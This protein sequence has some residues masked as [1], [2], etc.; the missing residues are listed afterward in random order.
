MSD[1]ESET[2]QNAIPPFHY[3]HCTC[4]MRFSSFSECVY[5]CHPSIY[6]YPWLIVYSAW[7]ICL[8]LTWILFPLWQVSWLLHPLPFWPFKSSMWLMDSCIYMFLNVTLGVYS[9]FY[10]C[11][12]VFI[13]PIHIHSQEDFK[14]T[15]VRRLQCASWE[16]RK[17]TWSE[18]EGV[19]M[20][21][22]ST[23][24][25]G[26]S[27]DLALLKGKNLQVGLMS[28]LLLNPFLHLPK[29]LCL[30]YVQLPGSKAA[31]YTESGGIN[32][33]WIKTCL[34]LSFAW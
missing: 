20:I 13:T 23:S 18:E 3:S 22:E 32:N 2:T 25:A 19:E 24:E 33:L 14:N 5:C 21:R 16:K 8:H 7:N 17:I 15:K 30:I 29:V 10:Y 26:S 4:Y 27:P 11:I 12:S 28:N 31:V 9:K 34:C 6:I 1:V